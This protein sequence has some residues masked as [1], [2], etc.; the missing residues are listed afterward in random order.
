M[1][2]TEMHVQ[3]DVRTAQAE[4]YGD[5]IDLVYTP[6]DAVR[7]TQIWRKMKVMKVERNDFISPAVAVTIQFGE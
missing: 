5:G 1:D 6:L 3:S 4:Q 2:G 7:W